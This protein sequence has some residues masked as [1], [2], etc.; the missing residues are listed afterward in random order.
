MSAKALQHLGSWWH[1]GSD[2]HVSSNNCTTPY[3]DT[4]QYSAVTVYN[5]IVL[6][7][8]MAVNALD[9]ISMFVEGETLCSEGYTLVQFHVIAYD[10]GSTYYNTR[11]VVY[12]EVVSYGG[13]R[14]YIYTGL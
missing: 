12:G 13:C 3:S 6:K 7:Y 2:P 14:M 8:R 11:T 9:G 10:A 5:D 1:I 4:P